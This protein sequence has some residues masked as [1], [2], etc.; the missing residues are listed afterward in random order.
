[1][2]F[3]TGYVGLRTCIYYWICVLILTYLVIT[4][5]RNKPSL[6]DNM[7]MLVAV[8]VTSWI[9]MEC[10]HGT[11]NELRTRILFWENSLFQVKIIQW[12]SSQARKPMTFNAILK[13]GT[14]K[15][16]TP[17]NWWWYIQLNLD[18]QFIFLPLEPRLA[19][20]ACSLKIIFHS[21]NFK[22]Y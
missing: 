17:C 20:C 6:L 14:Q 5:T 9:F 7:L 12:N 4:F 11:H 19:D 21:A 13:I 3:I 18:T 15:Y 8:I 2:K 10:F 16:L 22:N 1:M